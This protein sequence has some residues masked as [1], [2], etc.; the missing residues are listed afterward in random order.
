MHSIWGWRASGC[1]NPVRWWDEASTPVHQRGPFRPRKVNRGI[2]SEMTCQFAMVDQ[3]KRHNLPIP[4]DDWKNP[5]NLLDRVGRNLN[6]GS[7]CQYK[8]GWIESLKDLW[9]AKGWWPGG[10]VSCRFVACTCEKGLVRML[11]KHGEGENMTSWISRICAAMACSRAVKQHFRDLVN[12]HFCPKASS[13]SFSFDI[14]VSDM[15]CTA[16][17]GPQPSSNRSLSTEVDATS[18]AWDQS[19]LQDVERSFEV[20]EQWSHMPKEG[21]PQQPTPRT[22]D[23]HMLKLEKFLQKVSEKPSR[24]SKMVERKRSDGRAGRNGHT[25]HNEAMISMKFWGLHS[26]ATF[27]LVWF[28]IWRVF[29]L[30]PRRVSDPC[31]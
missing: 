2:F 6:M 30:F 8:G 12:K 29:S 22:H 31:F 25:G 9:R 18:S 21:V 28:T 15:G 1:E 19:G 23:G 24:L 5:S 20:S 11:G 17:K 26:F 4:F 7:R 16:G 13:C 10:R 3:I 27:I 14:H